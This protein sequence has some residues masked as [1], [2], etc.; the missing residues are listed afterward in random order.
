MKQIED[1]Q[2][3]EL[4]LPCPGEP[5]P[6]TARPEGL[7]LV[8]IEQVDVQKQVRTETGMDDE[9]LAELGES[10]QKEGLLQLPLLRHAPGGLRYIIIAGHR[11][12]EAMKRA[13]F[14]R[15]YAIVGNA[16]ESKAFTMQLTENIQREQLNLKEIASAIRKLHDNGHSMDDISQ[17]VKKSKAWV[18]KHLAVSCD[19]FSYTAKYMLERGE[20]EDLEVLNGINQ[21]DRLGKSMT[22]MSLRTQDKPITR[23]QVR[24]LVAQAK[25]EKRARDEQAKAAKKKKQTSLT[26][27]AEEQA[28]QDRIEKDRQ[29]EEEVIRAWVGY[30]IDVQDEDLVEGESAKDRANRLTKDFTE[31]EKRAVVMKTDE[32]WQTG[33]TLAAMQPSIER[34]LAVL[35]QIRRRDLNAAA[36]MLGLHNQTRTF[37]QLAEMTARMN[38]PKE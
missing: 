19:D 21:L 1:K 32:A 23:D 4:E 38:M 18:S 30:E 5:E 24:E 8:H 11:R 12:I 9:S 25:E 26:I 27:S 3:K 7:T 2:T 36:T 29:E 14:Q 20:C 35:E 22:V 15:F 34:D 17:L 33:R 13:G 10:I 6:G 31:E 37:E 28:E 16:D